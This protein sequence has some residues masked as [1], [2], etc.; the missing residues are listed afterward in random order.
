M[1]GAVGLGS[2]K[3]AGVLARQSW[4][5][6]EYQQGSEGP[7]DERDD[8]HDVI[9]AG[10]CAI[11]NVEGGLDNIEWGRPNVTCSS[12]LLLLLLLLHCI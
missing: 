3:R 7:D 9:L 6:L 12:E 4:R 5:S 10:I 11:S 1:T 8:S 2:Q